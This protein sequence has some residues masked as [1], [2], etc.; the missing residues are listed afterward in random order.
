MH[1][2]TLS[3][4]N[5]TLKACLHDATCCMRLSFWRT[6]T[7]A[8]AII[9]VYQLQAKFKMWKLNTHLLNYIRQ[10]PNRLWHVAPYKP[11]IEYRIPSFHEIYVE[12][13]CVSLNRWYL[14]E[15]FTKWGV[16][17][18]SLLVRVANWLYNG[19]KNIIISKIRKCT[20]S[21]AFIKNNASEFQGIFSAI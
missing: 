6:K 15:Q 7:T 5:I 10:N 14:R 9:S 19:A 11:A 13:W 4:F 3:L 18:A 1:A 2:F 20:I 12:C 21:C 16:M 8:G 17:H